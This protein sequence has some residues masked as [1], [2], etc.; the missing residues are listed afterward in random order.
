MKPRRMVSEG[1][2]LIAICFWYY[3]VAKVGMYALL[4]RQQNAIYPQ[5]GHVFTLIP[6]HFRPQ[7]L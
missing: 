7:Y 1:L 3:Y 6:P 4:K 2:R 5:L